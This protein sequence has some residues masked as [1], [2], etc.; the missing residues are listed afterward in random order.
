MGREMGLDY[1][2]RMYPVGCLRKSVGKKFDLISF[3]LNKF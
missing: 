2:M 3:L 1:L